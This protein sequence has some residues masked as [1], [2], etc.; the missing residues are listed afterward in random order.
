MTTQPAITCLLTAH[1]KPTLRDAL[2]SILGQT[3]L[4]IQV[5]VVD[6]GRWR[7][8][9]GPTSREMARIHGHYSRHPLIEWTFTGEGPDLKASKCPVG[10]ATNQAIR[11]GLVRGRY[12]CTFYDDD[13]YLPRFM[14]VMAGY[15]DR[16]PNAEA[17]WCTQ[18]LARLE[19]DGTETTIG[20]R[21]ADG[22]KFGASFDCRVDG[23]Q[24]MWHTAALDRIGDPW[25]P[26]DPESCG[27]SDGIFLD[28]LGNAV[29]TVPAV[30]E[31]LCV[32]RF[33]SLSAYTPLQAVR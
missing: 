23:A 31:A 19:Q 14:E 25:L 29:G 11:A 22:P 8:R 12:M 16:H 21:S 9:P 1:M 32:H 7:G 2:D 5:L 10:W 13:R 17:V 28:K 33:T 26:E 3:R 27:H 6:S 15:L 18:L 24:V 30:P 4:D 20:I